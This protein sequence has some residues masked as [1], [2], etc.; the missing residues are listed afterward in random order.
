MKRII[1]E[2]RD[3]AGFFIAV[4]LPIAIVGLGLVAAGW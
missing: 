3:L 1:T 4:L 2:A